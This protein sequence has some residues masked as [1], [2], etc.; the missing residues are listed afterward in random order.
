MAM[1]H[2]MLYMRDDITKIEYKTYINELINYLIKSVKGAESKVK[3]VIDVPEM[4]L[5]IDTAIPSG[6]L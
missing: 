4:E 3:V 6:M 2:E 5:G 1:V